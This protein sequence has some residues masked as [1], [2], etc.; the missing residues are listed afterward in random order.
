MKVLKTYLLPVFILLAF[1]V[2]DLLAQTTYYSRQDGNWDVISTWSTTACGGFDDPGIPGAGDHVEICSGDTVTLVGNSFIIN[3][4]INANGTLDHDGNRLDVT[5]SYTNNGTQECGNERLTLSGSGTTIDGTGTINNPNQLRLTTGDKTILSTANLTVNNSAG[6]NR[7]EVRDNITITNNGTIA[8]TRDL[9]NIAGAE[10]WINAANSTLKI[11]EDLLPMGA[12]TFTASAPG[13][14]V[15]YNGTAD[16]TIKNPSGFTYY[17]LTLSGGG[18]KTPE[19]GGNLDINGNVTISSTFD[20]NGPGIDITVAGNW[21]NTGAFTELARK[22][23]FDGGGAQSLSANGGEAFYD[24]EVATGSLTCSDNVTVSS[25]AGGTLTM[26]GNIDMQTN[27]LTLGTAATNLGTLTRTGGTIIGKFERWIETTVSPVTPVLFPVGTSGNYRPANI[28]LNNLPTNGSLICEFVASDPQDYGNPWPDGGVTARNTYNEGYWALTKANSLNSSDYNVELT[29]EGFTSFTFVDA[30]RVLVRPDATFDWAIEGSH[31]AGDV[32]TKTAKRNNITTLSAHLCFADT[33]N[34]SAPTTSAITG[35]D[36]VCAGA[37]GETYSVTLTSGNTYAWTVSGGTFSTPA[38]CN[39]FTSCSGVD[40]NSVDVNWNTTGGVGTLQVTETD[41][42]G[43]GTPVTKNVNKHPLPTS[44]ITG[45]TSVAENSTGEPYSVINNTGYTY[46][47]T[48]TGGTLNPSPDTDNSIT[49][50]WGSAGAGEV[51]V[52]ATAGTCGSTAG[53]SIAVTKTGVV[54]SVQDGNWNVAS[55]WDCNCNPA[56]TDNAIIRSQDTVTLTTDE[57]I[58]NLTINANAMVDNSGNRIIITGNYK[59]NGVHDGGDDRI[60]LTGN[61]TT[62]DGTGTIN[63]PNKFRMST[64]NKTILSTANLT[65]NNSAGNDRVEVRDNITVTN[66]GTI[67]FTRDL[68]DVGGAETWINAANSTLKVG[69]DLFPAG[70]T[71]NA[72]A[73]GNTVEYNGTGN[74][75]IK[76]PLNG[77]YYHLTLSG[78]GIKSIQTNNLDIDGNAT[79]SSTFNSNGLDITVAG[80]WNNTGAFTEGTRTVT[81][82][83]S[84]DQTISNVSTERFYNLTINKSAGKWILNDN[85]EVENTLTLTSGNIDAKTNGKKLTLGISTGAIGTLSRTSGHVIGQFERWVNSAGVWYLWSIG[86]TTDYRPDSVR[87]SAI[88]TNGSLISEFIDTDPQDYGNPWLDG[89]D[90]VFRTFSEGYWDLTRANS[91]AVTNYDI[92]LTGN[93][94]TSAIISGGTRILTRPD[95]LTDWNPNGTHATASNSTARRTGIT[96]LSAHHCFGDTTHCTTP[97]T[98]AMAGSD[99][100]CVNENGVPYS[101]TPTGGSTYTWTI[102]G[103]L[104]ASGGT[105]ASITVDWGATGMAGSVQVVEKNSGG[106]SGNPVIKTVNIHPLPTSAIT[107]SISVAENTTGE[108]YSVTNNTGYVYT[109]TITGGT[110]NPSPDTDNSITVDW[111]AAGAGNVSVVATVTGCGSAAAENLAV[112]KYGNIISNGTG[113]GFWDVAS[114]WVCNCVPT[115]S[116]NAIIDSSDVVTLQNAETINHLTIYATA[117]LTDAGNDMTVTGN[118]IVNGTHTGTRHLI[119]S[120]GGTTIDG[121]GV[122]SNTMDIRIQGGNKTILSTAVLTKSGRDVDIRTN[123]I[124]VTNNGN[125]TISD[126]NRLL[127]GNVARVWVNAANATFN[128]GGGLFDAQAGVLDASAPGNTVNY[129]GTANQNVKVPSSSYYNLT[130]SGGAT[131]STTGNITVANDLTI[132][133][134]LDVTGGNDQINLGGDWLNTGNFVERSGTLVIDGT[135]AQS[136]TNTSGEAFYNVT[137]NKTSGT[138]TINDD[139]TV[140][141]TAGGTL[142]MTSGNIITGTDTLILGTGTGNVGNLTRTGGAVVGFFKRWF[143]NTGT[144]G[145]PVLFPVG[146]STNYRPAEL[147]FTLLG[148]NGAV[149]ADFVVAAPG[150]G[151]LPLGEAPLSPPDST[152]NTFTEGYWHIAAVSALASTDYN[153]RLT[154]NGFTSYPINASTRVLKRATGTTDWT[155]NGNHAG[156]A[157]PTAFRNNMN[158]ISDFEFCFGDTANC[159]PPVTSVITGPDS[160]CINDDG[161]AYF[162]TP[163]GGSTY[164]WTITGGLKASGGNTASITVDWGGTSGSGNVQVVETNSTGCVGDPVNKVVILH[165]LVTS[166]ITGNTNVA[167]FITGEPYSVTNNT[168][169]VYTWTITGGTK[170]GGGTTN[171]I[172]V[173]WGS[174]GIGDVQVVASVTGCASAAAENLSVTKFGIIKSII[175]GDWDQTTTWDCACIPTDIDNV[176]IDSNDV[177]TLTANEIINNITIYATGTLANST[178]TMTVNGD[179]T[180]SGTHSG[181]GQINLDGAS[182]NIDGNTGSITN[183]A[184][185]RITGNKTILSG[186]SITKSSGNVDI[187]GAF[188]VF[189]NGTITIGGNLTGGNASATWRQEANSSLTISGA[190][191]V[192]G[193]LNAAANNNTVDYNGGGAQ[194]VKV[195]TSNYHHLKVTNSGTKTLGG[196]VDINGN[197]TMSGTA[198]L[199]A[200]A[201]TINLAGNWD[202]TTV[203][204]LFIEGTSTVIFDGSIAQNINPNNAFSEIFNSLTINK[205]TGDITLGTTSNATVNGTMTLTSGDIITGA[206]ILIMSSSSTLSG[207]GVSSHV[208]GNMRHTIAAVGPTTVVFPVGNGII[209]RRINLENVNHTSGAAATYTANMINS[210]AGA[211]GYTVPGTLVKVSG[212]RHWEIVR[213]GAANFTDARVRLYWGGDDQVSDLPNLAVAKDDGASNWIDLS[214]TATGLPA[215]GDILSAVFTTFSKFALANRTGGGNALPIELLS[216]TAK[217]NSDKVDLKWVTQTETNNDYYTVERAT[218]SALQTSPPGSTEGVWETVSEVLGAGN[219][220]EKLEY[221]A[222][223]KNPYIGISYYRLKQT[224]FDGKFSYSNIVP[225]EYYPISVANPEIEF[226]IYPNPSHGDYVNMKSKQSYLPWEEILV[227]VVDI[228]GREFYSKVVL[229]DDK[230]DF[231]TAIDPYQKIPPGIY[232]V[233]GS[234]NDEIYSEILIVE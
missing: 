233:M 158:N 1:T 193:V 16:Q 84:T 100:V 82:D 6:N 185:L 228:N 146:T 45:N 21:T 50:D 153:L 44:A 164:N 161:V 10:T 17:H 54:T 188:T 91:L 150:K 187:D 11:G 154:G 210:S 202:N 18:I 131:K 87:F 200:G 95:A 80:N 173:N 218:S 113:G 143:T 226:I 139:V 132:S 37:G 106:C 191:L 39:G 22:V 214:G 157:T 112:T 197:L 86:T 77:D 176:I 92:N 64:G 231:F 205:T 48:I 9:N 216:F 171:N 227:V 172:T 29:G 46:A 72:S 181:S 35:A 196:S 104:K 190:L 192:T 105:S 65:I 170:A 81:I 177:V 57:T 89:A 127:G 67:T 119:L 163:T 116:D 68:R 230:G 136:I 199:D 108:P 224:D 167:E 212:I 60:D 215:S 58:N 128:V 109:W 149:V 213:A 189:N 85:V 229:T 5:G 96:T 40:Y 25:T 194:T 59:N 204:D 42:C 88:T 206:N 180:I 76:Y 19:G 12:P 124:T 217:L 107:G 41:A 115:A 55:T 159:T 232:V 2:N 144:P 165:P 93:G 14:T 198:V 97:V 53:D 94:F 138:L 74:Q 98:S 152:R 160:V 234:S 179:Y 155:L 147:T 156:D 75:N 223:D 208:N 24:L 47:W 184:L 66:N 83:G 63:N 168:G 211:L 122:I 221:S 7:A 3:F 120:G 71:L 145:A 141:S 220:N 15:E 118:L 69:E 209:Y 203:S 134:T 201:N 30:I 111:G 195:P 151:G 38:P 207:G 137:V 32:P 178:F 117:I 121:S 222:I 20:I 219:S 129:N 78:G 182:K 34:C 99:S 61:G 49:V 225:V 33:T 43:S 148:T 174:A 27:T 110:L 169:Y 70:A 52:V 103:G 8:F 73:T 4:T 13:N 23:T 28:T 26:S 114:T 62:I 90:S 51:K 102:T 130:I 166:T 135:V 140:S 123:G 125:F 56:N 36:S 183:T 31:V 186:A 101:V 79:I 142:T 162:V 175:T 126:G 133:S